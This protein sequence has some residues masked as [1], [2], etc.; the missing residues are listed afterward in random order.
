MSE[1]PKGSRSALAGVCG[2]NARNVERQRG[3]SHRTDALFLDSA[4][5]TGSIL[6]HRQCAGASQ[7]RSR[8]LDYFVLFNNDRH[9]IPRL[10]FLERSI[11]RFRRGGFEFFEIRYISRILVP[12]S[13]SLCRLYRECNRFIRWPV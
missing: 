11:A 1:G 12:Y 8:H 2:A 10:L 9:R 6:G 4:N 7:G 13:F 3:G 5:V